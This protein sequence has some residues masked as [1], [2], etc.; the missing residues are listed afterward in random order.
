MSQTSLPTEW[1]KQ[2]SDPY[3]VLGIPVTADEKKILTRYHVL[4][5]LLHPDRYTNDNSL[6]KELATATFTC[7]VNPAYEQLKNKHERQ[8]I[9]ESL[10]SEAI[11]WKKQSLYLQSAIAKQMM[12]M[13]AREADS[14]YQQAIAACAEAQYKS[15]RKSHQVTRQIITLN[16]AYL[17]LQKSEPLILEVNP[18]VKSKRNPQPVEPQEREITSDEKAS[19]QPAVI[20]YAPRHYQ[21]GLQYTKQGQ[22]ASAVQELR[23]AI[24]LE[25]S[26]SDYYALLGFVYLRQSFVGMAKVY[27]RQA[28]KLNPQQELALKYAQYL[29][30]DCIDNLDPP[31]LAKA[32]GIAAVLSKFVT[33]LEANISQV[34][35]SR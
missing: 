2:L 22:W 17:S 23:D 29:K 13:S 16:L 25:P 9:L 12:A 14:F 34:L 20:N 28:L 8:S 31:S 21:R 1:L 30:I 32:L 6:E 27:M 11:A 3:A 26:N 10:R 7:L 33:K 18:P 24:K 5:K 35:K 4:A 19:V 15:P